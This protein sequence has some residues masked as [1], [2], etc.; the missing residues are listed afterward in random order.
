MDRN[1]A[2]LVVDVQMGMFDEAWPVEGGEA[3]LKTIGGLIGKARRA[4][5][6]VIYVQHCEQNENDPLHP[7]QPGWPIHPAIAPAEGEPVIHK[8]HPDS[9]QGTELQPTLERLGI[10]HLILAGMQTEYC[11]DT[12]CRR[13]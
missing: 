10:D 1:T 5:T 8:R 9:F 7:N 11:I 6:P 13:A 2:L 4:G 3:L 12:T